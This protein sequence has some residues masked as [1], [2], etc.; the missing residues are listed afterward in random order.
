VN[1]NL[2][3]YRIVPVAFI[4]QIVGG[5]A[6]PLLAGLIPVLDGS[7]TTVL[8]ALSG[9]LDRTDKKQTV[10]GEAALSAFE[11]FDAR[12]AHA[13]GKRNIHIPRPLL[14]SLRNTFRRKGRL[15]LTLFT[16]TMAGAIFIA[17]F[18]VRITLHDYI[19]QIG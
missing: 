8:H 2:L 3:G 9:G 6:V 18:N 10:G 5:L 17:V 4:V 16:L 7:R 14:I 12:L 19:D 13:L 11:R 1:F 15:A